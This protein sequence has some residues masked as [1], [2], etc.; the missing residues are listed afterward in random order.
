MGKDETD[1]RK[2][3]TRLVTQP[4]RIKNL[5]FVY[6]KTW[7]FP[8]KR[9]RSLNASHISSLLQVKART[10]FLRGIEKADFQ[11]ARVGIEDMDETFRSPD[12]H[13]LM[14]KRKQ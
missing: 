6:C 8:S 14:M 4:V 5:G 12:I 2:M 1:G 9:T 11:I 10:R 7:I 13:I 3:C